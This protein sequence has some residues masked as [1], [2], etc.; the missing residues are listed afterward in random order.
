M[1]G[2][3]LAH[4]FLVLAT[5]CLPLVET[6]QGV[7]NDL[8]S[9]I[10]PSLT[11]ASCHASGMACS[12]A[13]RCRIVSDFH[14]HVLLEQKWKIEKWRKAEWLC[15]LSVIPSLWCRLKLHHSQWVHI[16]LSLVLCI[17]SMLKRSES[18]SESTNL[19]L[20]TCQ[21]ESL[22]EQLWGA[23]LTYFSWV[24]VIC[25]FSSVEI[26]SFFNVQDRR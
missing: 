5:L 18:G 22:S 13:C 20:Q 12:L 26:R 21:C 17:F 19:V 6:E 1:R 9:G 4:L 15:W 14:S 10:F 23:E 2:L 11:I 7:L 16:F 24:L 8:C 25:V 3:E